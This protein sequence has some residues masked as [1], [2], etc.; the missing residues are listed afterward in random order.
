[1]YGNNKQNT[2]SVTFIDKNRSKNDSPSVFCF[3][4]YCLSTS[5]SHLEAV[6]ST[7]KILSCTIATSTFPITHLICPLK[8]CVSI[9]FS[10]SWDGG[11]T[12]EKGKN[13]GHANIFYILL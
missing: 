13:K 5:S 4:F 8:F 12:Q 6:L 10:F 2:S 1:M 3:V 9:V 11:N 7:F